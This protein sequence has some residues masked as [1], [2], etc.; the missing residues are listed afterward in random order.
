MTIEGD[1]FSDRHIGPNALDRD[2][3][4]RAVGAP[5]LDSLIDDAIPSRIRLT[6]PLALPDGISE[7]QYLRELR[8]IATRNQVFRSF[9]GFG[10]YGCLTPSVIIRNVLENPGWYTP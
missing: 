6:R 8:E 2:A 5:T 10:Y 4:L 3:M 9:L 7:H 1:R